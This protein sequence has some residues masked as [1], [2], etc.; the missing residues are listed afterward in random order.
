MQYATENYCPNTNNLEKWPIKTDFAR[1]NG[2]PNF[3]CY[4]VLCESSD[5]SLEDDQ[6]AGFLD[7]H[8]EW[9]ESRV[10]LSLHQV[11]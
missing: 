6:D 5:E 2:L 8:V 4:F 3:R 10:L 7:G 9:P 1:T 11:E